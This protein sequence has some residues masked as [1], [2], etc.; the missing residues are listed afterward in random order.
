MQSSLGI[1]GDRRY[2]VPDALAL[3]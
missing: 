2:M 3:Y 1:A